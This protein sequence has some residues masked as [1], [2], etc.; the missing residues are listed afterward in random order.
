MHIEVITA[1]ISGL[2]VAIPTIITTITSNRARDKVME[3]RMKFM[4]EKI[5]DLSARV[6]KHNQFNDRLIIVEQA[7]KSAHHRI[8]QLEEKEN[9]V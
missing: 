2:C 1:L 4:T 7:V 8:E 6:D 9:K 5:D 3:E